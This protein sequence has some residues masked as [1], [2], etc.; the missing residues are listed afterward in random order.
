MK[1][2]AS[3]TDNYVGLQAKVLG[4]CLHVQGIG[5]GVNRSYGVSAD[6]TAPA[7]LL[8]YINSL[9]RTEKS[10]N[11]GANPSY[12]RVQAKVL[13]GEHVHFQVGSATVFNRSYGAAFNGVN[14]KLVTFITTYLEK[15]EEEE[16]EEEEYDITF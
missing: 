9:P 14:E 6:M 2:F 10:A 11:G 1:S 12:V 8:E 16:E 7:N 15:E 13:D 4:N 3:S 5:P